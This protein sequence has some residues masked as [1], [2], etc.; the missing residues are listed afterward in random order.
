M[1]LEINF[2]K[3]RIDKY[4]SNTTNPSVKG[5]KE[6]AR[7]KALKI[8]TK[9]DNVRAGEQLLNTTTTWS[10]RSKNGD[11]SHSHEPFQFMVDDRDALG[12]RWLGYR[13]HKS[14]NHGKQSGDGGQCME[15]DPTVDPSIHQCASKGDLSMR[16]EEDV[17]T[18]HERK[19]GQ[20]LKG[21]SAHQHG[22]TSGQTTYRA[23]QP[24]HGEGSKIGSVSTHNVPG[25]GEGE[26]Q[27]V[28]S[29]DG[30]EFEEGNRDFVSFC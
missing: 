24:R 25:S 16:M 14:G 12:L 1:G 4:P 23:Q 30:M 21:E 5:K 15:A 6:I 10:V 29:D 17:L 26:D 19:G 7:S 20:L 27:G 8:L 18:V 3:G 9:S 28:A 22:D 2:A 11:E 13:D